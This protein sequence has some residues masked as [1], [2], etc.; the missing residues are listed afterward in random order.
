MRIGI[1]SLVA[2]DFIHQR[3]HKFAEELA[4]LGHT[5]FYV[6][7]PDLT[8]SRQARVQRALKTRLELRSVAPGI[9]T[10][11]PLV[12]P[13]FRAYAHLLPLNRVLQPLATRL[14]R[15]LKLDFAIVL[16]TE[17]G[18]VVRA[19]GIPFAYD[20]VDDTQF[21]EHILTEQFVKDMDDLRRDGAFTIYIQGAEARRDP[22]G[23]F[24][25]NG[26]DL[27][28]FRPLKTDKLFDAVVLSNIA[29]WFDMD[30]IL[31]SSKRILLIGPMDID[32]GNNRQRFFAANRPNL[33][34]IP[35]VDK[36]VANQWLSRA[37]VGLVPFK[38]THPVVRYAMPIKILEYFLADLPV[39]TYHNEGIEDM[40][41]D[42]VTFYASDGSQRSLD[43]AIEVAKTKRGRAYGDFAARYQWNEIVADLERRICATVGVPPALRASAGSR[44]RATV[45]RASAPPPLLAPEVVRSLPARTPMPDTSELQIIYWGLT[46]WEGSRQRPQHL[47]EHLSQHYDVMYVRPVAYSRLIRYRRPL[48]SSVDRLSDRLC[49]Y[50][51]R[52]MS[53]GRLEPLRRF[54]NNQARHGIT[55]RLN[56][57]RPVALWLSHPRQVEQIGR[58]GEALVCYDLMDYHAAFKTGAQRAA[59]V[60]DEMKLLRRAD[61]VFASSHDLRDRA[62][63][64]AAKVVLAPNAADFAH[65]SRAAT[66]P[67]DCPNNLMAIPHPRVLFFGTFGPWV[68]TTLLAGIAQ[69]RPRWSLVLIGPPAGADVAGLNALPNCYLLGWRPYDE[70]PAFLQHSAVCLLPFTTNELT[71]AVDPVKVYEYLAAG[72]PVVATELPELAKC[73]DLIDTVASVDEAVRA[74]ERH[75]LRPED[76]ARRLARLAFAACQTWEARTATI[77]RAIEEALSER[78]VADHGKA[79]VRAMSLPDERDEDG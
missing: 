31:T 45:A 13:P 15:S 50:R 7:P 61:L 20:H 69:A 42:M 63:T 58:Y 64:M 6:E 77:A 2:W 25:P 1:F 40:Y 5:I 60:A 49:V 68:D 52:A 79:V 44:P 41:G 29:K 22:K 71:R 34:W 47:A 37:E 66:E 32:G 9:T 46:D 17:Y 48:P 59:V 10:L 57:A 73:G 43:D 39:V 24:V 30:A 8:G 74:I 35:Q 62:E 12:I 27:N 67:L 65:F 23:V 28:Q 33:L 21:M 16:A 19:L 70:L 54:N 4:A 11:R 18:P 76:E 26:A 56:P 38:H 3:P 51:P 53:P 78:V 72:K 14:L 36:Q 55:A 75:L